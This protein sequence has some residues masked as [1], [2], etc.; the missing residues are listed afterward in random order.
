MQEICVIGG[1]HNLIF[2][3]FNF[4]VLVPKNEEKLKS[5]FDNAVKNY[6]IIYIEEN[7]AE[8]IL[9]KID[10]FAGEETPIITIINGVMDRKSLGLKKVYQGAENALNIKLEN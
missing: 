9:D 6:K 5:L 3:A 10:N 1:K 2:R 4:D 8:L 7:Y